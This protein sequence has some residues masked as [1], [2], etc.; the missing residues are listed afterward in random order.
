MNTGYSGKAGIWGD[1]SGYGA[2]N[3]K[4]YIKDM[5]RGLY[6]NF[7]QNEVKQLLAKPPAQGKMIFQGDW[8]PWH[9]SNVVKEK[10]VKPKLGVLDWAPKIPDLNPIETLWSTLDK[11]LTTKS[12]YSKVALIDH[13]QG[14]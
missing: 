9:T 4:I 14:E 5:N 12:F 1:I 7:L 13:I 6:Y 10:I 11:K 2:I 3:A 8:G